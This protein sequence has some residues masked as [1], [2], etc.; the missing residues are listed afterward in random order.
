MKKDDNLG[1]LKHKDPCDP[2]AHNAFS[3]NNLN[4]GSDLATKPYQIL[5]RQARSATRAPAQTSA[6]S[7]SSRSASKPPA[8][9]TERGAR[10]TER[11]HWSFLRTKQMTQHTPSHEPTLSLTH[12]VVKTKCKIILKHDC[13]AACPK[14]WTQGL[15][16]STAD[17]SH[18][19]TAKQHRLAGLAGLARLAA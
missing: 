19:K 17:R 5:D 2:E 12:G 10:S 3:K 14:V 11:T 16:T 18:R 9:K 13:L 8:L 15:S 7:A 6:T 1:L 4:N